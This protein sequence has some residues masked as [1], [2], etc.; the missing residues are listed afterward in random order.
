MPI[1]TFRALTGLA[2]LM[3]VSNTDLMKTQE[4]I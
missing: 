3:H 1:D 2:L 4:I